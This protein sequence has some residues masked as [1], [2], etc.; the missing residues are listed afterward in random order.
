MGPFPNVS[1]NQRN[2]IVATCFY[3]KWPEAFLCDEQNTC[4][5]RSGYVGCSLDMDYQRKY[6]PIIGHNFEAMNSQTFYE[7]TISI[8]REQYPTVLRLMVWW[9][10]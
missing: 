2:T 10:D 7:R 8:I 1:V 5:I 3:T 6:L 9:K 4:I